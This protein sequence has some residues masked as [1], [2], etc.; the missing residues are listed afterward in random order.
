MMV[1]KKRKKWIAMMMKAFRR[2][3]AGVNAGVLRDLGGGGLQRT[4]GLCL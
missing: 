4:G 3:A 1:K 2:L